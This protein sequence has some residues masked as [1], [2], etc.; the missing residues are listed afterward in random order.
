M[1]TAREGAA[2][3][4]PS[5]YVIQIVGVATGEGSAFDGMYLREYDPSR[6]GV[7]HEGTPMMSHV[8]GTWDPA[9]ALRFRSVAEAHACWTQVDPRQP[10]RR[11][12]KPN[13]PLTAFTVSI[14]RWP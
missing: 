11:D 7:D 9:K 13:R 10:L 5:G 3:A 1:T 6:D 12:G 2:T 4:A 14:R 8:R